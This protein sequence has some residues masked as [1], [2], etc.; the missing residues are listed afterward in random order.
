MKGK[1]LTFLQQQYRKLRL[2]TI[3][4]RMRDVAGLYLGSQTG[5]SV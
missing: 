1:V 5:C 2:L 3:L 4:Y